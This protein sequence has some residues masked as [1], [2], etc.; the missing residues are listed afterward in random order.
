MIEP[1]SVPFAELVGAEKRL[2]LLDKAKAGLALTGVCAV[3]FVPTVGF[4]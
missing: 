3:P 1:M 4:K 2:I